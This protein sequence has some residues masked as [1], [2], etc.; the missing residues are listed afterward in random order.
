MAPKHVH[1]SNNFT[2]LSHA[3]PVVRIKLSPR[4][5]LTRN[6]SHLTGNWSAYICNLL[7]RGI[8]ESWFADSCLHIHCVPEVTPLVHQS[9]PPGS[10]SQSQLLQPPAPPCFLWWVWWF[11]VCVPVQAGS[12][13]KRHVLRNSSVE[14]PQVCLC[15]A[16]RW[17][18]FC[19]RHFLKEEHYLTK[20]TQARVWQALQRKLTSLWHQRSRTSGAKLHV[21]TFLITDGKA[22]QQVVDDK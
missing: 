1:T 2:T 6:N 5:E 7:W 10:S 9:D 15:L 3:Y 13:E 22:F 4:T 12:I 14:A 18:C 19:P 11:P 8:R 16:A 20:K 21:H 17:P